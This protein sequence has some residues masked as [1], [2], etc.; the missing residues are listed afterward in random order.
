MA[1]RKRKVGSGKIKAQTIDAW[2]FSRWDTYISCPRK[3]Y[4]QCIEK[5]KTSPNRAMKR[6]SE[7]HKSAEDF[8]KRKASE[9]HPELIH[10]ED[11][12][13]ELREH[14]HVIAEADWAF[15]K[16]WE[17][18]GWFGDGTWCRARVDVAKWDHDTSELTIIDYK[19]GKP[20]PPKHEKQM[21]L[22]GLAGLIMYPEATKVQVEMWYTD[23]AEVHDLVFACED[24]DRLTELWEQRTEKMLSDTEFC[25]TPGRPQPCG[26]CDF[27][28]SKGG[29][30]QS[31]KPE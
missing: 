12:I 10:F 18:T 31:E 7:I 15:T 5:L 3:A 27:A 25:P 16:L 17:P 21:E 22:Y 11:M 24:Q 19:T 20:Y 8:V 13:K 23:Q 14:S 28:A 6:G 26:W 4:Y 1:A 29:P 30:C 9:L 2:S